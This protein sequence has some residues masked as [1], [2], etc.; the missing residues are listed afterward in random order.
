MLHMHAAT[1][2]GFTN[3]Y[4]LDMKDSCQDCPTNF[5]LNVD[6]SRRLCGKGISGSG[7]SSLVI[8]LNG[9]KYSRVRGRVVAYQYASPD[10]FHSGST[11]INGVYVDGI[12]ITH[13]TNPR[14]HVWTLAAS[15]YP[16]RNSVVTCPG[17]GHGKAQPSFVGD[18][19]FCSTGNLDNAPWQ[20]KLYD[21]PLF[22]TVTGNCELCSGASYDIPY[23]CRQLPQPTTDDLEVRIC[24]NQ[25]LS[26]EDIRVESIELYIQ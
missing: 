10:A 13:G 12:S 2:T 7:C 26:D 6:G 14:K 1:E 3:V 5:K 25:P 22:S 23:F 8:P 9:Q 18:N 21:T 24:L 4:F 20:R 11:N 15:L 17:T 19:Y 16:Y